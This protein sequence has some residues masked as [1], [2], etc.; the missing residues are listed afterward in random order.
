[1]KN[2]PKP[3]QLKI[4]ILRFN[5]QESGGVPRLQ[6]YE[7]EE[8]EGMTLFMALNEIREKQ[9]PSLQFDFVCRA[10]SAAAAA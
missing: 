7:I 5:P 3:R 8:A 10:G 9:E 6:T 1:M 4:S 2:E